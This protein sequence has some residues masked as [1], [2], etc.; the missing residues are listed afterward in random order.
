M[1]C[2]GNSTPLVGVQATRNLDHLGRDVGAFDPSAARVQEA[3][4]AG[5]AAAHLEE[6]AAGQRPLA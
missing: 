5:S 2:R 4:V 6:V 3:Q 1:T